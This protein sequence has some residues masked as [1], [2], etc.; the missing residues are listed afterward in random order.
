MTEPSSSTTAAAH[1]PLLKMALE[2]G[3]VVLF[4]IANAKLDIFYATAVL[5]VS[6]LVSLGASWYLTRRIPVM[7]LVTAVMVLVFGGLTL[8]LHDDQFIKLKPTIVN[9]L[10]GTMLLGGLAFGTSF[11][12][13][14]MGESL[15]M[16][17]KGWKILTFRWGIFFFVLAG[18]NE[19]VWRTQ[20][21]DFWVSFKLFGIMPLTLLFALS[22]APLMMK[23]GLKGDDQAP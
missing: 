5:M 6:V 19:L 22:Q 9:C 14:V 18:L 2:T 13:T 23:H 17:H 7:P 4:F 8:Y 16:D 3:P 20:T 1:N 15:Q 10:F 11:L 12:E 21:T